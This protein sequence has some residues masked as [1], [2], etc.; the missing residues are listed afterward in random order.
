MK[1]RPIAP[2]PTQVNKAD[3]DPVAVEFLDTVL[4]LHVQAF[5]AEQQSQKAA[6]VPTRGKQAP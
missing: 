2:P 1:A 6:Q 4:P 3:P 5:L